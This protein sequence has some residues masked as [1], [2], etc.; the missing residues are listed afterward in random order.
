[1]HRALM[2]TLL[3]RAVAATCLGCFVL[4]GLAASSARAETSLDAEDCSL[5]R[6][7]ETVTFPIGIYEVPPIHGGTMTLQPVTVTHDY[8]GLFGFLELTEEANETASFEVEIGSGLPPQEPG[9]S[10]PFQQTHLG[11]LVHGLAYNQP[12]FSLGALAAAPVG[13]PLTIH[14]F[15]VVGGGPSGFSEVRV[16]GQAHYVTAEDQLFVELGTDGRIIAVMSCK[17]LGAVP[18]PTCSLVEQVGPFKTKAWF[19]RVELPR[20]DVVRARVAHFTGCLISD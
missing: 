10:R 4:V 6:Q 16:E 17:R 18:N 7:G 20:L 2:T 15:E 19:R 11:L 13:E 3:D 14:P 5:Y 1:M 12:G 9:R 8:L